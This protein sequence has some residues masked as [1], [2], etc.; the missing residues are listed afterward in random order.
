MLVMFSNKC[1]IPWRFS[2]GACLIRNFHQGEGWRMG[3]RYQVNNN[4][5]DFI[6]W[7]YLQRAREDQLA[8]TTEGS[9]KGQL[10]KLSSNWLPSSSVVSKIFYLDRNVQCELIFR[11]WMWCR[12]K[13]VESCAWSL[14]EAEHWWGLL[15]RADKQWGRHQVLQEI[16]IWNHRN[17]PQLLHKYYP[18]RLLCRYQVHRPTSNQEIIAWSWFSWSIITVLPLNGTNL[19][20]VLGSEDCWVIIHYSLVMVEVSQRN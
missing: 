16:W 3:G 18:T 10:M 4:T 13:A 12:Y 1:E 17:N 19:Y 7:L 5:E 15:A 11:S 20:P 9:V 14:H 2:Y 6:S 8:T